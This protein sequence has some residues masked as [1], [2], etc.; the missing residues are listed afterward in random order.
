[1]RLSRIGIIGSG[2]I[3]DLALT[4]LANSIPKPMQEVSLL[5][6]TRAVGKA[7]ALLAR[8]GDKLAHL[9]RVRTDIQS[10]LADSPEIV[11]ECASHTAVHDFAGA[12]V[13]SGIDLIVISVGALA[14]ECFREGLERDGESGGGR[15]ILP[16]GAIGAIDAL[17]SAKLSGLKEVVYTGRKPPNGWRKTAAEDLIDLDRL[18][19]STV[20]FEGNA[21]E[22]ASTFPL[23]ANVAATLALA[24]IGFEETKVML[25]ADPS[26][27]CNVHQ[28]AVTA[29]CGTFNIK[30][31]GLV[32]KTNPKTSQLAGYSVAR[33]LL[34]R[35]RVFVI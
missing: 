1:M 20:F 7:E 35:T 12:I 31:E 23:N 14:D 13:S 29:K 3:A 32:S 21:L 16:S 8:L 30:L 4:A 24:G 25:I 22:A 11:A 19:H 34:N 17:S 15:I 26:L 28:L 27:Q 6:P 10:F 5:V 33:E 2:G 9:R 18:T